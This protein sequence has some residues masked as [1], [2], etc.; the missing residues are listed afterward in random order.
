MARHP[1]ERCSG[2][3]GAGEERQACVFSTTDLGRPSGIHAN[4]GQASC[5]FCSESV[6]RQRLGNSRGKGVVTA[7]LAFFHEQ[8]PEDVYVRAAQRIRDVAG[9]PT[10]AACER[11]LQQHLRQRGATAQE[12]DARAQQQAK[13]RAQRRG[14]GDPANWAGLLEARQSQCVP[15]AETKRVHE[16]SCA[17]QL[18][19]LQN[20]LPAI[21]GENGRPAAAWQTDLAKAFTNFAKNWSWRMCRQCDRMVPQPFEPKHA[22]ASGRLQP[23]L[24]ACGHCSAGTRART[25]AEAS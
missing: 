18:R 22:R 8:S 2:F 21:Y 13:A 24:A 14:G 1:S 16:R 12:H 20:K 10:W 19:A 6:L 5:V 9:E 25:P 4:R 15:S 17:S 7:A 23:T 11:R 3:A